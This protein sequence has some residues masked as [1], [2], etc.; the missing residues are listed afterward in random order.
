M[1]SKKEDLISISLTKKRKRLLL[2]FG[3][4]LPVVHYYFKRKALYPVMTKSRVLFDAKEMV[5]RGSLGFL[6]TY[7]FIFICWRQTLSS[8]AA[9]KASNHNPEEI[10]LQKLITTRNKF[11]PKKIRKT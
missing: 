6:V 4:C 3:S 8:N 5:M 1:N 7:L 10:K 9:E 2:G 11:L